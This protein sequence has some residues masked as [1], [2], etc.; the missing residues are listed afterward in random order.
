MFQCT[1]AE[2]L[3]QPTAERLLGLPA[4]EDLCSAATQSTTSAGQRINA[5]SALLVSTAVLAHTSHQQVRLLFHNC[6]IYSYWKQI[7]HVANVF[8][9]KLYILNSWQKK[10]YLA[11]AVLV[12]LFSLRPKKN[13]LCLMLPIQFFPILG[14]SKQ[15]Y[16]GTNS[17]KSLTIRNSLLV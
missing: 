15:R 10:L 11:V 9:T 16:V 8:V 13:N 2:F 7:I 12:Q 14:S 3:K 17:Y 6:E 1:A 4:T 5:L